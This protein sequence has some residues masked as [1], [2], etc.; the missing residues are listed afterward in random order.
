MGNMDYNWKSFKLHLTAIGVTEKA[1]KHKLA[2]LLTSSESLLIVLMHYIDRIR[3]K[4]MVTAFG[5][6]YFLSAYRASYL[7][8][9]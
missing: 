2:L 3:R 6:I 7:G 9:K 4:M 5:V 8:E 1:D